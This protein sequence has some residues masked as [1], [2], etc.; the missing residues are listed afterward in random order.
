M[1]IP[2]TYADI[3]RKAGVS[4]MT[5][6]L[7]MRNHPDVSKATAEKI[8]QI[9]EEMGYKPDPEIN[10]LMAYLR[11]A[12]GARVDSVVAFFDPWPRDRE[13][14][15]RYH[16]GRLLA[17]TQARCNQLGFR[18]EVLWLKEP[19]MTLRRVNNILYA[20][21]IRGVLIPPLPKGRAHLT[22][23]WSRFCCVAMDDVMKPGLHRVT[24]DQF[25]NA[26]LAL[27]RVRKLHYRRVGFIETRFLEEKVDHAFSAAFA[28]HNSQV[29]VAE[30]LPPLILEK[31]DPN[32]VFKY[33]KKHKPDV[34]VGM[35]SERDIQRAGLEVPGDVAVA[36]LY[37]ARTDGSLAGINPMPETIGSA[38]VDLLVGLLLRNETGVPENF[39][40]VVMRGKWTD[41]TTAPGLASDPG[42][43]AK[44]RSKI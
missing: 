2:V 14:V 12:R 29:K 10:R 6:S 8:M 27:R 36:S 15:D 44:S 43:S 34:L 17:G 9:A 5:V 13:V 18:A 30:R 25:G 3:A 21:G 37:T 24:A 35:I 7:A 26:M 16:F 42:K 4:R 11:S 39:K 22:L 23:D 1:G 33:V 31:F 38:A 19:G 32:A 41:G 20:R 28:W 40:H